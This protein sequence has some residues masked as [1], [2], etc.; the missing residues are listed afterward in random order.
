MARHHHRSQ[1]PSCPTSPCRSMQHLQLRH[2]LKRQRGHLL[3][4]A[5]RLVEAVHLRASSHWEEVRSRSRPS[6]RRREKAWLCLETRTLSRRFISRPFTMMEMN[7]SSRQ[8]GALQGG[9]RSKGR[10]VTNLGKCAADD[11]C[12]GELPP[13]TLICDFDTFPFS[14]NNSQ[15][16]YQTPSPCKA[17][18]L[19]D[20]FLLA[21]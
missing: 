19:P 15:L 18:D 12:G 7:K 9:H 6:R 21:L 11:I 14:T 17:Y 16:S 13:S 2:L 3:Q 4:W 10:S 5:S 20:H 1:R 8:K